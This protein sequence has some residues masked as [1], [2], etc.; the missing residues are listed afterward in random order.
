MANG[1]RTHRKY[2]MEVRTVQEKLKKKIKS[3]RK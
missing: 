1:K 2:K 3:R